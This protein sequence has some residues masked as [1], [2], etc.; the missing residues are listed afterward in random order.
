M[1][2]INTIPVHREHHARRPANERVL[3]ARDP[4]SFHFDLGHLLRL[5][6]RVRHRRAV[7][8]GL[9]PVYPVLQHRRCAGLHLRRASEESAA[10]QGE[11]AGGGPSARR[12]RRATSDCGSTAGVT[13]GRTSAVV[14]GPCA[15]AAHLASNPHSTQAGKLSAART[16]RV[17]VD[18]GRHKRRE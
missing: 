7:G 12:R 1:T 10:T 6:L 2:I 9:L 13:S 5:D 15:T 4:D 3:R 18:H 16:V 11:I 17:V 14:S 8:A